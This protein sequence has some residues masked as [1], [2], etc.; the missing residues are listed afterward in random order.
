MLDE[1][2]AI[3]GRPVE[4]WQEPTP[5]DNLTPLY[6]EGRI[7]L[8]NPKTEFDQLRARSICSRRWGADNAGLIVAAPRV[9]KTILLEGNREGD[10]GESSGDRADHSAGR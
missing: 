4:E 7:I 2:T 9:G 8:E 5:F 10:P 1:V 6:P 3:E